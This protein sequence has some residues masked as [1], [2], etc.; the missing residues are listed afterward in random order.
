M[1]ENK[2]SSRRTPRMT[3]NIS[4]IQTCEKFVQHY[5]VFHPAARIKSSELYA[6]Y[7]A[8]LEKN[9]LTQYVI[10][11]HNFWSLLKQVVPK[12]VSES[13]DKKTSK[14][15]YYIGLDLMV[16]C[17]PLYVLDFLDKTPTVLS[18]PSP[19]ED[20]VFMDESYVEESLSK[21][22]AVIVKPPERESGVL[23]QNNVV[24][25][26]KPK[27]GRPRKKVDVQPL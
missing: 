13:L 3:F 9:D 7:K 27:R 22:D 8:F 19:T 25:T 21:D 11:K 1:C 4:K 12:D 23:T 18:E 24:E 15:L 5:L 2:K 20:I 17:V 16:N 10:E 26:V 14:D 6:Q